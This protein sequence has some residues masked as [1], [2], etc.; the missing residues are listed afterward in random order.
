MPLYS[1]KEGKP[2]VDNA[3]GNAVR[4]TG[5]DLETLSQPV[6]PLMMEAVDRGNVPRKPDGPFVEFEGMAAF[7]VFDHGPAR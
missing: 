4:G 7:L 6:D 1:Q 3:L 2:G 5:K